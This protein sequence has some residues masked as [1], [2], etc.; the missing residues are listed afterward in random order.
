MKSKQEQIQ[1]YEQ[2]AAECRALQRAAQQAG[3]YDV[4]AR[5]AEAVD[6]NL[7]KVNE[8]KEQDR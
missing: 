2:G 1:N 3:R 5:H 6:A 8:L 7:D 4:A